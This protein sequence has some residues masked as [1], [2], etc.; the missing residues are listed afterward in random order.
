MTKI[1]GKKYR[2]IFTHSSSKANNPSR[3]FGGSFSSRLPLNR[4]HYENDKKRSKFT[5]DTLRVSFRVTNRLW[6]INWSSHKK[7]ANEAK[8]E[9]EDWKIEFCV[10]QG[11]TLYNCLDPVRIS[12]SLIVIRFFFFFSAILFECAKPLAIVWKQ[13]CNWLALA[14]KW[15]PSLIK[16]LSTYLAKPGNSLIR[17]RDQI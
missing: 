4:L 8:A 1:F 5:K 6:S 16:R 9:S 14:R 11:I 17:E 10:R 12:L 2:K 3:I 15:L 7:T 13:L